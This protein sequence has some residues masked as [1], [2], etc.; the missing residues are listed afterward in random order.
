[1]DHDVDGI[2]LLRDWL[3]SSISQ[4]LL[5][6]LSLTC[7]RAR[8]KLQ[9]KLT[10]T[11]Y[12]SMPSPKLLSRQIVYGVPPGGYP[13]DIIPAP[14]HQGLSSGAIVGIIITILVALLLCYTIWRYLQ[15][16]RRPSDGDVAESGTIEPQPQHAQTGFTR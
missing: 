16:R 2:H 13:V 3:R 9:N 11:E 5:E 15:R 7:T 8:S 4:D 1:M 12:P 10:S 6:N 14:S